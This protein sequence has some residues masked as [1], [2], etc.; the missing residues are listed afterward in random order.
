MLRENNVTDPS[1]PSDVTNPA[2]TSRESSS[3]LLAFSSAA[4]R[5]VSQSPA[6]MVSASSKSMLRV[7]P[8]D[9]STF[10]RLVAQGE[11][12]QAE[13]MLKKNPELAL[14][15]GDSID[16]SKRAFKGITGFQ[17]AIWALD[18][19]MWT[20]IKKYL[21]DNEAREQVQAMTTGS[22]I[23]QYGE[24]V[25]WQNLINALQG[26][27]NLCEKK[28]WPEAD[29]QWRQQVGGAQRFLPAH[30]INEYCHPT[31][32]FNPCPNFT[33][34]TPLPRN[35]KIDEEGKRDWFSS[36]FL[37]TLGV[38]FAISRC[39]AYAHS[40]HEPSFY[41]RTQQ[42]EMWR[43]VCD[44]HKACQTLLNIRLQQRDQFILEIGKAPR[45]S[46]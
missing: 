46:N 37:G 23:S 7:N 17:Y 10:L 45:Q 13:G 32:H 44:D 19:H 15:S 1:N 27:I 24:S 8:N 39:K 33:L 9:L 34:T 14:C 38:N 40:W 20:M 5:P 6:S 29:R 30:V 35:R 11:Q 36:D 28:Q 16:L 42:T 12:D 31:R 43:T 25:S 3:G 26:F 21:P 22:W 4:P 18:W 41:P 2:A